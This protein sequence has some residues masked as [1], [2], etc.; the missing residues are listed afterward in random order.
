MFMSLE[1]GRLTLGELITRCY[2]EMAPL[3]DSEEALNLAV[4]ELMADLLEDY[5]AEL[6]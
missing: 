1:D 2:D 6:L 3:Y 5:E 4:A